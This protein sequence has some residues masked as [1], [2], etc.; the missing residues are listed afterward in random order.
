[1]N[2]G[3]IP[4]PRRA[5]WVDPLP[6]YDVA[7]RRLI[8]SYFFMILFEGAV[9]KWLLPQLSAP[10]AIIRD[11]VIILIY[12]L[13]Y[14]SG[15][16]PTS[17][18]VITCGILAVFSFLAGLLAEKNTLLVNFYGARTN[19]L[20]MPMIFLI[21]KFFS[22]RD[23]V[24]VGK[25]CLIILIPVSMLMIYQFLAPPD[26][27][28]NRTATGEGLQIAGGSGRIRP[29]GIFT[30]ATG[31]AEF[32]ALCAAFLIY[33]TL[34]GKA[35]PKVLLVSSGLALGM[36]MMTSISRLNLGY[37]GLVLVCLFVFNALRPGFVP[38]FIPVAVLGVLAFGFLSQLH[39]IQQSL[40]AFSERLDDASQI[41][42]GNEGMIRRVT[43][44]FTSAFSEKLW[45][46]PLEG[47]GLGMG[48]NA[49]S[50]LLTGKDMYLL[51]EGEW[52]R[53]TMESG[54]ILGTLYILWRLL[55]V[56]WMWR[57]SLRLA[58]RGQPLPILLFGAAFPLVLIGQLGR[59]TT[60]GFTVF[61]S[62][63]CVAALGMFTSSRESASPS[64]E[65]GLAN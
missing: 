59:P 51:A 23:V 25:W 8:W 30:F 27:W 56:F 45:E 22:L 33:G 38:R 60:L 55:L 21:P 36:A 32:S 31:P 50:R 52:Q 18:F 16:L 64:E 17:P 48:T 54:P 26:A 19:F 6:N 37:V 34:A 10:I 14:R 13:A 43:S 61:D 63:L 40:A 44:F 29:P 24:N 5:A 4:F 1:M 39:S 7:I 58:Y 49:G 42:G 2:T 62:A 47:Y 41:E 3:T 9:R 65:S 46:E 20:H 12:W 15:K 35:Y 53:N 28:I 57:Q 11:P